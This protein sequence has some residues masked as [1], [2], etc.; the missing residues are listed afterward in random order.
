MYNKNCAKDMM[1]KGRKPGSEK[2]LGKLEVFRSRLENGRT[3]VKRV[4]TQ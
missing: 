3:Y 4:P 1:Y 2:G